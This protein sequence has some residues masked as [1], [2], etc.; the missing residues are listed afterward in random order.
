MT[1][2]LYRNRWNGLKHEKGKV[3]IRTHTMQNGDWAVLQFQPYFYKEM[4]EAAAKELFKV[5]T[6]AAVLERVL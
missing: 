5:K 3:V 6:A 2:T 4:P 1:S